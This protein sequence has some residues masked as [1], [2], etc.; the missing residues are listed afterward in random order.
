MDD[1]LVR[2]KYIILQRNLYNIKNN[3]RTALGEYDELF[4]LTKEGIM[5]DDD[6]DGY[7]TFSAIKKELNAIDSDLVNE[8]IPRVNNNI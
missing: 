5:I 6:V 3:L 1:E 7:E 2:Q 4:S 8:V